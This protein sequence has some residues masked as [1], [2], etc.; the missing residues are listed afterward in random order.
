M[1]QTRFSGFPVFRLFNGEISQDAVL[2]HVL[3]VFHF[4]G[5]SAVIKALIYICLGELFTLL[6][7]AVY[8]FQAAGGEM[9]D[10]YLLQ[11]AAGLEHGAHLLHLSG[12]KAADI[13][14]G[15]AGAFRKHFFHGCDVGGIKAAAV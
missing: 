11:A 13:Q 4:I 1:P 8:V 14:G 15:Q 12:V 7:Y 9:A 5:V 6:E 2:K 3:V 10:I